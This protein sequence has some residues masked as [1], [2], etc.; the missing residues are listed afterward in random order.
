MKMFISKSLKVR[1][2]LAS[3][4]FGI[5]VCALLSFIDIGAESTDVGM[6]ELD[7]STL[8]AIIGRDIVCVNGCGSA[9]GGINLNCADNCSALPGTAIEFI[10]HGPYQVC[11]GSGVVE[12]SRGSSTVCFESYQCSADYR[13]AFWCDVLL[14]GKCVVF[15]SVC[16]TTKPAGV[17]IVTFIR[18]GTC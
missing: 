17:P 11:L 12:C 4:V 18:P 14:S 16:V 9:C 3:V 10:Y 5:A 1:R 13:V 15:T 7:D 8:G 2:N 6:I